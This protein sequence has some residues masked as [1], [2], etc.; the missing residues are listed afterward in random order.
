[1]VVVHDL[2]RRLTVDPQMLA[3]IYALTDTEAR[4]ASAIAGGHGLESASILLGM[5]IATARS[6]LKSI[7]AKLDVN[8]QQD[9]VRLITILAAMNL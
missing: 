5:Q 7:F 2:A 6:H 1:M 8:R 4:L 3:K 9:M